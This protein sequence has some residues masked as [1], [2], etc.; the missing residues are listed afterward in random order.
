MLV[1]T[2]D[3]MMWDSG[4]F[5]FFAPACWLF[6][7]CS[8]AGHFA[9]VGATQLHGEY[10]YKNDNDD[11]RYAVYHSMQTHHYHLLI[12]F[13][14]R[15]LQCCVVRHSAHIKKYGRTS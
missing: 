1:V 8:L 11:I 15:L 14:M 7:C 6:D 5:C 12:M 2:W 4:P 3:C 9:Q 13:T 10:H